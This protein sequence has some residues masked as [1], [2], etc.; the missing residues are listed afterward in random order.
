MKKS[1]AWDNKGEY[2]MNRKISIIILCVLLFAFVGC[3]KN[4]VFFDFDFKIVDSIS[5]KDGH[6][7]EEV[8]VTDEKIINEITD[9]LSTIKG[10]NKQ[11][12]EGYSGFS[13]EVNCFS[14]GEEVFS[15][16]FSDDNAFNYGKS[17]NPDEIYLDRYD[18][19]GTTTEQVIEFFKPYYDQKE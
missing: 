16:G 13:F 2:L 11:S 17:L 8:L 5:I 12:S 4:T 9:F 6:N 15:I 18:F 3:T 7:G 14:N 1:I 10:K 19:D